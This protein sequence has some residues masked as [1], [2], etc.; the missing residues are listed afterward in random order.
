MGG[1]EL[2]IGFAVET[3]GLCVAPPI[4]AQLDIALSG[5]SSCLSHSHRSDIGLV[6]QLTVDYRP[7]DF[8]FPFCVWLRF[9][10]WGLACRATALPPHPGPLPRM[11]EETVDW[12][13][14]NDESQ[15][16]LKP[17]VLHALAAIAVC[18]EW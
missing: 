3:L 2:S 4:L 13:W 7:P 8:K 9:I 15:Q 14:A 16:Y 18:M 10:G 11:G 17:Q 6:H 5:L 12:V 1:R